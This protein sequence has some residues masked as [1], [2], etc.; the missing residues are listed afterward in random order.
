MTV[1][2]TDHGAATPPRPRQWG[3]TPQ[4]RA[5]ILAAAEEVFHERGYSDANISEIVERAGV[6]V[7]STYHH[8]GGKAD[9]YLAL[10]DERQQAAF[11]AASEAV[12]LARR[13]GQRDPVEQFLVGTRAYLETSWE[14]RRLTTLSLIDDGP[15]G[16]D[17]MRRRN[18]G[19][20]IDQNSTLLNVGD[21]VADRIL[22]SSVTSIIGDG[23]REI[24][25]LDDRDQA[26]EGILATLEYVARMLRG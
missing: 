9:I 24:A 3:R 18:W 22:V 13:S 16:F 25:N 12:S 26:E 6:S 4:T 1:H 10:W 5:Q 2:A 14:I 19:K 23:S 17:A 21:S 11:D 7:G 8:F 20:W 15:P